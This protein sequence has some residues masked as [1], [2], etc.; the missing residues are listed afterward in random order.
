MEPQPIQAA[1]VQAE[2]EGGSQEGGV[3]MAPPAFDLGAGGDPPPGSKQP[4]RPLE[5]TTPTTR[6][7]QQSSG[8]QYA[9]AP[10]APISQTTLSR[11]DLTGHNTPQN[12]PD[13]VEVD[14]EGSRRHYLRREAAVAFHR[15]RQAAESAGF[16]FNLVSSTRNFF[17]Q[18]DI[19][20]DKWNGR[21]RGD[22]G[23]DYSRIPNHQTR[24]QRIME[25]SSMPGSSRHH[26]GTDIDIN[27]INPNEWLERHPREDRAGAHFLLYLWLR[28]Y[29]ASFGWGQTYNDRGE[30]GNRG[31]NEERWHWSYV[32]LAAGYQ[33]QYV[34]EISNTDIAA[35]GF[36]GANTATGIDAVHNYV[37]N[38][39]SDTTGAN[40]RNF[41]RP[42]RLGTLTVTATSIRV[43]ERPEAGADQLQ[44]RDPAGPAPAPAQRAPGAPASSWTMTPEA[45]ARRRALAVQQNSTHDFYYL[46]HD[47]HGNAWA[48]IQEGWIAQRQGTDVLASLTLDSTTPPRP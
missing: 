2:T 1:P 35:M 30:R 8:P 14:V 26:W 21:T 9:Q 37:D 5:P 13:F 34:R 19:W 43:R 25:F 18:S 41:R 17:R 48:L 39:N 11:D 42:T 28:Q 7:P 33:A 45:V 16:T 6:G 31:Y 38:V 24:A 29:A 23:T 46:V 3:M 22:D 4:R 40:A 15:L 27:S 44:E 36:D 47:A 12:H 10:A 20:E 32:P